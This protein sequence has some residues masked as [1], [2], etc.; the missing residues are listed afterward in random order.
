M[1]SQETKVE[2]NEQIPDLFLAESILIADQHEDMLNPVEAPLESSEINLQRF[3]VFQTN[4]IATDLTLRQSPFL[5]QLEVLYEFQD[6][7]DIYMQQKCN[8]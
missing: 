1:L 7:V 3:S 5:D 4:E 6:L 8:N 2:V